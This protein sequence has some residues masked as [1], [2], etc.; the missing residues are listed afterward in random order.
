MSYQTT[1]KYN[2][3]NVIEKGSVAGTYKRNHYSKIS[4]TK[5]DNT[6]LRWKY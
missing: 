5:R 4:H 2:E 6:E 3:R 1:A